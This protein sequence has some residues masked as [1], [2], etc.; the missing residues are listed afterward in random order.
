M[1]EPSSP[2]SDRIG[3]DYREGANPAP[4][5]DTD[6]GDSL[7]PPYDG[8][9][10]AETANPETRAAVERIMENT[11]AGRIGATASPAVESVARDDELSDEEPETP[12]G[13]GES[14]GRRGEKAATRDGKEPGRSDL[15][16]EEAG[17]PAGTSD[18][19]D[20]SGV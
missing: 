2:K 19:R 20:I 12:L 14:V 9:T 17:R 16:Q 7:V 11:D 13:V 10:N 5:G 18:E 3:G 15:P 1:T 6:T 4:G 8:R